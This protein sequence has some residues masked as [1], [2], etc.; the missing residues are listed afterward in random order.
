ME[1]EN[2][3]VLIPIIY[4]ISNGLASNTAP[5]VFTFLSQLYDLTKLKNKLFLLKA[6]K[7]TGYDALYALIYNTFTL[8][9]KAWFD[10]K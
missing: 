9:E 1:P 2:E 5:A 4:Q 6:S 8:E 7:K 3:E 10:A